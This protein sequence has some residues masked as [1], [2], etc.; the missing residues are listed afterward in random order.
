[1]IN[2]TCHVL[3]RSVHRLLVWHDLVASPAFI[4]K[5]ADEFKDKTTCAL[6]SS[7]RPTSPI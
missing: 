2:R 1:M 4:V 3:N 7:G 5:A 6:I